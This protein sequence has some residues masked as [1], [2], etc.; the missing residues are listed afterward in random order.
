MRSSLRTRLIVLFVLQVV[1][2]LAAAGFYLSWELG[3]ALEHEL[4]QK[5]MALAQAVAVQLEP[6]MLLSLAPGDEQRRTHRSLQARLR[7]LTDGLGVRRIYVFDRDRRSLVDSEAGIPIG[8]EYVRLQ[9]DAAE[10]EKVFSGDPASSPL[11]RGDDDRLY[12]NGYAPVWSDGQVVAGVGIEAS[13]TTLAVIQRLRQRLYL[14]GAASVAAAVFLGVFFSGQI[15]RPLARLKQA[16]E[17]M[18]GG[19]LREPIAVQSQDEIGF[20]GR[21]MEE[22]RQAILQRDARQKAMLA[23]VAH[24]IRNPLGGIEL[25][26]GLLA[27]EVDSPEAKEQAEKIRREVRQLNRIVQSFLEY[28]RPPSPQPE[29]CAI[30]ELV[31]QARTMIGTTGEVSRI[32]Y[33]ESPSGLQAFADPQQLRQALMNLIRNALEVNPPDA[34]VCV[35]ALARS[36]RVR[37]SVS[38][39][40]PGIDPEL[41]ERIFDPFYTTKEGGTGLG[42]AIVKSLVEANGG[43]VRVEANQPR[44]ARFVLELPAVST[45]IAD[46]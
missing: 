22:M 13:A 9:F 7:E 10:V 16:A 33:E 19:H 12:K 39:H 45:E 27:D 42:L 36:D 28:A 34:P 11:F 29:A 37:I 30:R 24:E 26:A 1:V 40:G 17:K 18:A 46:R 20:L 3:G 2:I 44:G 32:A 35:E 38:D 6:E 31:E 23:G 14:L 5:L 21:T 25:F 43:N 8:R 41:R 4:G 15:I